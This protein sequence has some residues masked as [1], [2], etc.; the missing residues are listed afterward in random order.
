MIEPENNIRILVADGDYRN[1]ETVLSI[2]DDKVDEVFYAPNGKQAIEITLEEK[3]DVIIMDWEMPVMNGIEAIQEIKRTE[4]INEIPVIV[5][6]GVNVEDNNLKEALDA[7]AV[8]FLKKP[9]S[10]VEF[11]A[12]MNSAIRIQF[13]HETIQNMLQNAIDQKQRELTSMATL[14]YQKNALLSQM[15]DQV[16][17]L[18]RLTN[19]VFATDIKNIQKQLRSQLDLDKSWDSFRTHFEE[20]HSGFFEKLDL[21]FDS[22]SL[23]DRKLCAYIKMG[24]GNYEI[25]QMTSSSDAAIRKSINRQKKKMNLVAKEEIRNILLDF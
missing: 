21:T 25:S 7:G 1:V 10:K 17:R 22:L 9:F 6:T 13:Q 4:E 3:P 20:V 16:E 8:D 18:D 24:M 15:L 14:D 2:I 11:E 23:N 19:F 12:R 5:A